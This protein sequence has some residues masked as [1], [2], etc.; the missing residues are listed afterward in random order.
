M[1]RCA[2]CIYKIHCIH[3]IYFKLHNNF[4]HMRR[5]EEKRESHGQQEPRRPVRREIRSEDLYFPSS[6]VKFVAAGSRP[7]PVKRLSSAVVSSLQYFSGRIDSKG[8]Q[9]VDL[10]PRHKIVTQHDHR[11]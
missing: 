8:V 4:E 9:H 11:S 3:W 10:W 7:T 1:F 2:V 5:K 6:A